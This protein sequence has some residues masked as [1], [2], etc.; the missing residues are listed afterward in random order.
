MLFLGIISW[1][2]H[3][4]MG[5]GGGGGELFFRWGGTSFLSEGGAPRGGSKKI[6]RWGVAPPLWETL[7][8]GGNFGT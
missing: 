2:F 8:P 3:A 4:L 7:I 1:V 6:M 5:V